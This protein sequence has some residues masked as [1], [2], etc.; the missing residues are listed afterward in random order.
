MNKLIKFSICTFTAGML[1]TSCKKNLD[2]VDPYNLTVA[3]AYQN[4]DAYAAQLN[5]VYSG[6]ASPFYYNGYWGPT[7]EVLSDNT[8]ETLESLVNFQ[9]VANWDYLSNE[10]YF[11]DLWSQP[12]QVIYQA[13]IIITGIDKFKTESEPKYNRI[14]GQALAARAIA[15]FDLLRGFANN[16]D[17]NATEPG[18]PVRVNNEILS[19]ARNTVKEVYD[20]IYADLNK[21]ITLLGTVDAAVNGS[22]RAQIDINGARAAMAR[23]A[24]YAKDYA[25]AVSNASAAIS[26][27][28]IATIANYPGIWNDANNNEVIWAIQNNSGDPGSP[29]PSADVMSFRFS[30]STFAAHPSLTSLYSATSDVRFTTFY[31]DR[32]TSN[33]NTLAIQKFKGKGSASD[34]LVNFKVFRTSEMYLI[35]AEAYARL[36]GANEALATADINTL[37]TNRITGYT[38]GSWTGAPLLTEIENERRRELAIEGHR[39]FDLKRTNRTIARPLISGANGTVNANGNVKS[40]L[41]SSSIKW[42]WP[43]PEAEIRINSNIAQNSGY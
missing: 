15:H 17:R 19:P 10:G 42:N 7:T 20:A 9:R 3:S 12:Y 34:N 21:A 27:I 25:V 40:T 6:F 36:G 30:R 23:V 33:G 11:R 38:N 2:L 4:L 29:F 18:V 43:I 28:P 5:G 13:N 1:F 8:Y 24:L 16:L 41:A 32:P 22:T 37:R 31:F 39:W 26:A 14:L 35:R